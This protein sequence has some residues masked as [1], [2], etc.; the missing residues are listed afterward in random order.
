[1]KPVDFMVSL[2]DLFAVFVPG[3]VLLWLLP[4]SATQVE[5]DAIN[6]FVLVVAAYLAGS[7]ASGLGALAD[8]LIDRLFALARLDIFKRVRELRVFEK[9]AN[10]L[11]DKALGRLDALVA[12]NELGLA[13]SW[14]ARSFWWTQ[15]RIH[16][17]PGLLEL[18]RIEANQKLFRSLIV[19]FAVLALVERAAGGT[20]DRLP[21][22]EIPH[23]AWVWLGLAVG[24]SIPYVAGRF[25]FAR[26]V[27][28]LAATLCLERIDE[29]KKRAG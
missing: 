29:P 1:M 3:A 24:S 8:H 18:D 5:H 21:G 4:S 13:G 7:V 11:R 23:L 17:P 9:A 16:C 25:H 15:I 26:T 2:R 22:G 10:A 19:V 20:A 28:G 12:P 27:Y 6:V 14:S